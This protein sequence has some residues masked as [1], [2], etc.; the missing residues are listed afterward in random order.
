MRNHGHDVEVVFLSV[1]VLSAGAVGVLGNCRKE[2]VVAG[3]CWNCIDE[4]YLR[5]KIRAEGRRMVCVLCE[6]SSR[7]GLT[8]EVMEALMSPLLGLYES[9][10]AILP[11]GL[12]NEGD[13]GTYL[14][15]KVNEEWEVFEDDELMAK[16]IEAFEP[17]PWEEEQ[18]WDAYLKVGELELDFRGV[19]SAEE[20]SRDLWSKAKA[21]LSTTTRFFLNPK[22]ADAIGR[23]FHY[24]EASRPKKTMFYRARIA[25][26]GTTYRRSELGAP[27]SHLASAG[28]A[29][30]ELLPVLCL[31]SSPDVAAAEVRPHNGQR[32]II[33]SFLLKRRVRIFDLASFRVGS[34]FRWGDDLQRV[35]EF[36]G[37]LLMLGR[38]LARPV[39]PSER[40]D[41]LATQYLCELARTLGYD[42]VAYASGLSDGQNYVLFDTTVARCIRADVYLADVR[43]RLKS[44]GDEMLL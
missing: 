43:V 40:Y 19:H 4:A 14:F 37:F 35:R 22:Y 32:V 29:N 7:R 18:G 5:A 38:E 23:S 13:H 20:W 9:V 26:S 39:M 36:S 31:G 41:Y 30:A 15:E 44:R 27:P 21:E 2:V 6:G 3:V 11:V 24:A 16:L 34:P 42:G 12:L 33:G 10:D 8:L 28:R 17:P 1:S 25:P